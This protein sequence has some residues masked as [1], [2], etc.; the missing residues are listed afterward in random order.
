MIKGQK[1]HA[2]FLFKGLGA[3]K[4][5]VG[6]RSTVV[7]PHQVQCTLWQ[8]TPSTRRAWYEFSSSP[9]KLLGTTNIRVRKQRQQGMNHRNPLPKQQNNSNKR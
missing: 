1:S 7:G 5:G 4:K 9:H 3:E 6:D 2:T 8:T